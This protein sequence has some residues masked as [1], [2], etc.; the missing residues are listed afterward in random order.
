MDLEE[1]QY[2][3]EY[4]VY[5]TTK[6]GVDLPKPESGKHIIPT[7]SYW[8]WFRFYDNHFKHVLTE[9]QWD[10]FQE[11]RSKGKDI[12]AFMP[13]GNW[14]DSL[15]DGDTKTKVNTNETNQ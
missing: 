13:S 11:A 8:A 6:F 2:A 7:D 1:E 5:Q 12:S 10:A 4:L 9:E 15:E 3:L 14:A